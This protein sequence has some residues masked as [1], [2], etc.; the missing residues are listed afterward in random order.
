MSGFGR[1]VVIMTASNVWVCHEHKGSSSSR[2]TYI[3]GSEITGVR[4]ST[5]SFSSRGKGVQESTVKA[6]HPGGEYGEVDLWKFDNPVDAAHAVQTLL[7]ALA[8]DPCGVVVRD[9]RGRIVVRALPAV[10]AE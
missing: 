8:A 7:A 3:R 6:S 10:E 2:T 1:S 5:V 9:D 4:V